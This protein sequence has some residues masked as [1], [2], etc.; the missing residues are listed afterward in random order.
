MPIAAFVV[1]R[2]LIRRPATLIRHC[3]AE[4]TARGWRPEF[5]PDAAAA[6]DCGA[7]LVFAAGGDGTVQAC[8]RALAGTG[9]PLAIVPLG[10]ANLT[11]RALRIP[12]G[13]RH[14]IKAGFGGADHPV[15]LA[16]AEGTVVTSMAGLGIDATVVGATRGQAKHRLGWAAYAAAGAARLSAAPATFTITMDGGEP[17]TRTARSVVAGNAGLLPSPR[18]LPRGGFSLLPDA[19]LDDGV[20]DVG[21][22]APAGALGWLLVAGQVLLHDRRQHR[23][24]ERYQA[25]H[26][27]ITADRELPR[28][29]DGELLGPG[30]TLTVS[31]WPGALTVR[32]PL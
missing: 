17:L 16:R 9:I 24:L 7:A 14:A 30:R 22:L 29:A 11:A 26:V 25:R 31:V 13:Q 18:Y 10:T 27:E 3:A 1:N 2:T 6:L 5:V 15:D 23:H 19:R 28:Q 21:I 32:R 8:A 4:A 12:H 20:L